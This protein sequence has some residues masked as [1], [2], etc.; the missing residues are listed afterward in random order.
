MNKKDVKDFFSRAFGPEKDEKTHARAMLL[1]Y[2]IFILIVLL[3]IKLTPTPKA[4]EA[5]TNTGGDNTQV[6]TPTPTPTEDVVPTPT[7]TPTSTGKVKGDINYSYSYTINYNNATEVYLGKRIDDKH[8]FSY[9]KDGVT[10]EYAIK[11]GNYLLETDCIYHIVDNLNTYFKYCNVE[12]ILSLVYDK[13]ANSEGNYILTNKEIADLFDESVNTLT[14][15]NTVKLITDGTTLNG[16][17][18][19]FSN[20]IREI[21]SGIQNLNIK[22]EF[23]NIGKVEDFDIKMN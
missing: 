5:S 13:N 9:S 3:Y 2:F 1:I 19:D 16:I 15:E 17:I 14:G 21:D 11:D 12:K 8:K 7:P 18:L 22:M 10:L 4:T 6:V 23:A 20:Y